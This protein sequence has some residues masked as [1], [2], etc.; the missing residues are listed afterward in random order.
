MGFSG[1]SL[2]IVI[3]TLN[4]QGEIGSLLD[5]LES[6]S[7]TPQEILVVDSSSDDGTAEEVARHQDV[8]FITITREDFNHGATRDAAFR[9]TTGEFVC[10]MTQDAVPASA[11]YLENL[12]APMQADPKIALASGRQLP[13]ADARRFEQLVRE[14]NYPDKPSTRAKADLQRCGIKTFFASD[15]CSC[16][17]REA[18]LAC[19]GFDKVNTNEDMLMAARFVA[20]GLKVAYVPGAEVYHSHNMTPLQQ[21][22][23]N[24]AV[25]RFLEEHADDLMGAREMGEGGKLVKAVSAR[26]L[27][28]GRIGELFAFGV[29][30]AARFLGNRKGRAEARRTR[31]GK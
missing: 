3:P 28:E 9:R 27:R 26:L 10:F 12:L 24:R 1:H 30:C 19:G 6:Q 29:D 2:S 16:Y 25:G 7:L 23:R 20:V 5:L 17:R 18:Y 22:A 14:F 31:E 4:A 21:Y 15:A 11:R 8:E 13:K